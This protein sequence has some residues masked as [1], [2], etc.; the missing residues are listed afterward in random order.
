MGKALAR[1]SASTRS[2]ATKLT[3][4]LALRAAHSGLDFLD[5]SSTISADAAAGWSRKA[6]INY[7]RSS[8]RSIADT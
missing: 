8:P 7:R 5:G 3:R 1:S 4:T 2:S 6:V